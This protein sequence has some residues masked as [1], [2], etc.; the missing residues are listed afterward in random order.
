MN[1][2]KVVRKMMKKIC[3][4]LSVLVILLFAVF[5]LQHQYVQYR[6]PDY[7]RKVTIYSEE[8]IIHTYEKFITVKGDTVIFQ[9]DYTKFVLKPAK[10]QIHE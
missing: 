6:E 7:G 9:N 10:V 3:F 8:K 2:A 1:Y 4:W 5:D